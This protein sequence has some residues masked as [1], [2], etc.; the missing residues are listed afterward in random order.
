MARTIN[1]T[2]MSDNEWGQQLKN[3]FD[4]GAGLTLSIPEL[5]PRHR[6]AHHGELYDGQGF[7]K[8]APF[9]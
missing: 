5:H 4:L 1:T 3:N 8:D 7:G 9:Q 6:Q 2:S